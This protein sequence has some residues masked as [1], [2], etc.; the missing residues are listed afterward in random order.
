DPQADFVVE[1]LAVRDVGALL[2]STGRATAGS[3]AFLDGTAHYAGVDI[4]AIPVFYLRLVSAVD[5][6]RYGMW[7]WWLSSAVRRGQ[8][9]VNTVDANNLH[10][11]KPLQLD[12]LREAGMLVPATLITSD[13]AS[14]R[15]FYEK[16]RQVITKPIGGGALARLLSEADLDER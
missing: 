3:A 15:R 13:A 5:R 4:G 11:L 12:L 16:H 7:V 1:R 2:I 8:T 14:L 6:E 10:Q 9:V